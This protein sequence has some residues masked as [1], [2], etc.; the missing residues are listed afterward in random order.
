M[1]DRV[2]SQQHSPLTTIGVDTVQFHLQPNA[3]SYGFEIGNA[4]PIRTPLKF[5]AFLRTRQRDRTD[6]PDGNSGCFG[7]A[8][9]LT[10]GWRLSQSSSADK[11]KRYARQNS[12]DVERQISLAIEPWIQQRMNYFI[13]EHLSPSTAGRQ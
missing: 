4:L 10:L 6:I 2:A 12:N 9:T 3:A 8:G 7:W 13:L 11:E 1:V 5:V